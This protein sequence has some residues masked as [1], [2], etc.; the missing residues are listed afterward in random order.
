MALYEGK[1]TKAF[2]LRNEEHKD[3]LGTKTG[4]RRGGAVFFS[5]RETLF[6]SDEVDMDAIKWA[7]DR[8]D[9]EYHPVTPKEV[10]AEDKRGPGRPRKEE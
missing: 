8:G 4:H 9:I 7:A 1:L 5:N 2:M 6:D 10:K 3:W